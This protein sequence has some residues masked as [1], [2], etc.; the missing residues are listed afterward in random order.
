MSK[1]RTSKPERPERAALIAA[2]SRLPGGEEKRDRLDALALQ[3]ELTAAVMGV[4]DLPRANEAGPEATRKE[5]EKVERLARGLRSHLLAMHRE[6]LAVLEQSDARHWLH[7]VD[8]LGALASTAAKADAKVGHNRQPGPKGRPRKQQ[9]LDVARIAARAYRIMTGKPA[10]VVTTPD[11]KAGGA[12]LTFVAEVFD[13]LQ[14][15]ARPESFARQASKEK[16]ASPR[17]D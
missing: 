8:D 5:L 9:A 13:A 10:S 1:R 15:K 16:K 11:G 4:A 2:L 7:L 14:I 17:A 6:S 3:L 12:F